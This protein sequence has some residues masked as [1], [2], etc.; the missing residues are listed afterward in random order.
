[1]KIIT[2]KSILLLFSFIILDVTRANAEPISKIYW[3]NKVAII[4]KSAKMMRTHKKFFIFESSGPVGSSGIPEEIQIGDQITVKDVTITVN[5]IEVTK[6]LKDLTYLGETIIKKGDVSCA[7]AENRVDFP[8]GR[9]DGRMRVWINAS[10]CMP[11]NWYG[12]N[13]IMLRGKKIILRILALVFFSVAL[14]VY[15]TNPDNGCD[16]RSFFGCGLLDIG[17]V[18]T[19]NSMLGWGFVVLLAAPGAFLWSLSSRKK[20]W[21]RFPVIPV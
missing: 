18:S 19:L 2:N 3:A 12:R 4:D 1:M 11:I 10:K 20:D 9:D 5:F 21:L 17:V 8:S 16:S 15:L 14:L 6:H 7:F 13:F